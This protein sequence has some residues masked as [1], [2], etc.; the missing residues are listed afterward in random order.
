MNEQDKILYE[1]KAAVLKALAH[2]T[3]LWMAEQLAGGE[4]C[5]C[6]FVEVMDFDFSTISRHLAVLKRAGIVD[7]DKRGKQ[8]FYRLKVPCVLKFMH[9]V[10]EVIKTKHILNK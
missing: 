8:V 7:V 4:K 6:E 5:V 10:E 1:A 2:P 9:C 3:R